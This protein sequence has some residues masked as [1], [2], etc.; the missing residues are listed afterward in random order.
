MIRKLAANFVKKS[1]ASQ[2]YFQF[3]GGEHHEIDYQA[4]VTKNP[5]SGTLVLT[6][7][8]ISIQTK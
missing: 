8:I 3:S 4:I 6:Q 1:I 5:K 2:P 7:D